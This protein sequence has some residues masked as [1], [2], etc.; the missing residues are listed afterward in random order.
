M[1]ELLE[2]KERVVDMDQTSAPA[3]PARSIFR[4]PGQ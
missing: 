2:Q 3:I 1:A 4:T